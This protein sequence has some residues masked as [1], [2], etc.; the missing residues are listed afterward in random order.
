MFLSSEE[1]A[2]LA[3]EQGEAKR[4]AM[5]L[6]LALGT[7]YKAEKLVPITSAHLSGVSYKT[8]GD[9]GIDFLREMAKD[10]KVSVKTT[11]NPAG[12]DMH[13]WREMGIEPT[14]AEKQIEIVKL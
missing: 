4:K 9:G 10:G 7:I 6:L 3:G 1:E 11:L 13:R 14:F 12:M 8:I 2:I 5:E